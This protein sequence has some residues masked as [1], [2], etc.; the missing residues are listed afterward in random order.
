MR[1]G[2]DFM[3][4]EGDAEPDGDTFLPDGKGGS[5]YLRLSTR[6]L[7][8]PGRSMTAELERDILAGGYW[9]RAPGPNCELVIAYTGALAPEAIEAAGLIGEDRRDI[10]LLA[11]TSADRLHAGWSGAQRAREA[12]ASHAQSHVERLLSDLPPYCV[13]VSAVDGYPATLSWLGS[14][15]GHRARGLGVE[16]FGQTG[17]IADLFRHYGLD[18]QGIVRAAECA[19]PGR[20]LRHL[21]LV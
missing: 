15:H 3:Q 14:V 10:G 18:S 8:Q 2:F 11:V 13:L 20:R 7:E 19:S 9:H 6:P 5:L 21:R 1:F 17:T 4:R 12:G 16:H